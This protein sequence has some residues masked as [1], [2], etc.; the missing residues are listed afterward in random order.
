[1]LDSKGAGG[2]SGWR[3]EGEVE[4]RYVILRWKGRASPEVVVAAER[5]SPYR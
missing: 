3:W 5:G 2:C 4:E 1:M